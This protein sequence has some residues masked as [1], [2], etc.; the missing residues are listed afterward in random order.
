VDVDSYDALPARQ[1]AKRIGADRFKLHVEGYERISEAGR[2]LWPDHPRLI[3][4]NFGAAA[5]PPSMFRAILS[6]EPY[7]IRAMLI[8]HNN[9]VGTYPNAQLTREALA[10]PNLELLVVHELFMTA[11]AQLADYVLPASAWLEKSSMYVGGTGSTVLATPQTVPAQYERHSDY[12]L[13][14]DLGRRLGQAEQWPETM[15]ALWDEML[16]PGGLTFD[17][18]SSREQNW[19]TYPDPPL[20]HERTDPATGEP[21]GFATPSHKV[22]LTPSILRDLG[23]DPLPD[24]VEPLPETHAAEAYPFVLMSGS[25]DIGR[26]HQDHRQ[27]AS[28]RRQ[29]PDPTVQ[30]HPSTAAKLGIAEGDWVWLES[31]RGRIR[32]RARLTERVHPRVVE[33]ERWW[34]PE[35]SVDEAELFGVFET[36][37]NVLT[38]DDPALCDPFT[39]SWPFRVARCRVQRANESDLFPS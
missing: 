7:P 16:A 12:E 37:V 24:Y 21:L 22:E 23:Y 2:R 11:T 8:Q 39:G 18:L 14:R 36:S 28:L 34:Y 30:I 25:T 20:R 10:S 15:E 17:D 1:R 26:T 6:R 32:Q 13:C 31:P 33:A 38:E 29:H 5:H 3:G 4:A 27:V 35:R 9:A 19:V